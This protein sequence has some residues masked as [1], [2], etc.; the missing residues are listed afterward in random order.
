MPE[1]FFDLIYVYIP[2]NSWLKEAINTNNLM[3]FNS[4]IQTSVYWVNG[5]IT[6]GHRHIISYIAKSGFINIP[7]SSCSTLQL[8]YS[9]LSPL[10]SVELRVV[11]DEVKIKTEGFGLDQMP[12]GF[13]KHASDDFLRQ[14]YLFWLIACLCQA[15][16][17][18][19]YRCFSWLLIFRLESLDV[20]WVCPSGFQSPLDKIALLYFTFFLDMKVAFYYRIWIYFI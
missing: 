20:F 2:S 11:L 3:T 18:L 7:R 19:A 4:Q 15:R 10:T 5:V 6:S 12:Y 9:L 1:K 17:T 8:L 16:F 14:N 13:Y